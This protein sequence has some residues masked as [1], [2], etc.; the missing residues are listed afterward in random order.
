L[1]DRDFL[2]VY[3]EADSDDGGED[4]LFVDIDVHSE[5]AR[6][7][8]EAEFGARV[9][10]RAGKLAT[11][12]L[13]ITLVGTAA[14]IAATILFALNYPDAWYPVGQGDEALIQLI[15]GMGLLGALLL[16]VGNLLVGF[17]RQLHAQGVLHSLRFVSED[18]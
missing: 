8:I 3:E 12:G 4:E 16:I 17:G 11:T 14:M 5:P 9:T 7:N 18:Q 15:T 6:N 10:N 1:S 2:L 13:I